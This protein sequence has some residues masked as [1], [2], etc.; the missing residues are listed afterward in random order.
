MTFVSPAK[1]VVE[2]CACGAQIVV[3]E[4][5][6][7]RERLALEDFRNMHAPCREQPRPR[8]TL[9]EIDKMRSTLCQLHRLRSSSM[10]DANDRLK[11]VEDQLRTYLSN[12]TSPAEL[13]KQLRQER[14]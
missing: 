13:D 12:G 3:V 4:H 11:G 10:E 8:Y 5:E 7:T 2:T 9:A 6:L 14:G 1:Q